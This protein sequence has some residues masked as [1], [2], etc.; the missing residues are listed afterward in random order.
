MSNF[1]PAS[2]GRP[3][4]RYA[5]FRSSPI[6]VSGTHSRNLNGPVPTGC[7]ASAATASGGTIASEANWPRNGADGCAKI[8]RTAPS[9]SGSTTVTP[10]NREAYGEPVFGSRTLVTE[11]TTSAGV[12]G[13]P[14]WNTAP[15]RNWNR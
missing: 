2:F 12:T 15:A 9:P 6:N 11:A 7:R 5:S 13:R 14:L 1:S 3:L 4:A 8:N 10:V